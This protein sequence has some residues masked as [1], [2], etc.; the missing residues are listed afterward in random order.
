MT[1]LSLEERKAAAREFACVV[2]EVR[3]ARAGLGIRDRQECFFR[4]H[5]D[6]K[7]ELLPSLY[8]QGTKSFEE[9]WKLERRAFFEF[10]ARARQL[11]GPEH[12]DWD[13]LFHMQHHGFPTRLL[14]W[15][16][17]FGVAVYFSTLDYDDKSPG[18]PCIWMLNPYALNHA[19]WNLYRLYDTKYLARDETAN[20]SYDYGELLLHTHPPQWGKRLLWETPMAIYTYQRSER[21]FAQ[22]GWFTVHGLDQRPLEQIFC[23]RPDI[24]RKIEI[25]KSAVLGAREFIALA[26][27]DHQAMFPDLDGLA[28]SVSGKFGLKRTRRDL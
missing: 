14:D 21:M 27:I 10:R 22:C 19:A 9:Y 8:R 11:Y 6:S 24:L 23:N 25:P 18:N 13:V 26:G 28:R 12:A 4:G 17:T 20:R 7:Y 1:S 16:S 15:T 5:R 2:D 3:E